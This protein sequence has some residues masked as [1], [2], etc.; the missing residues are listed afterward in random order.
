MIIGDLAR[1]N[2]QGRTA[3][4]YEN[5]Q[6]SDFG[7]LTAPMFT[8]V[9]PIMVLSPLVADGFDVIDIAIRLAELKYT[10]RYRAIA[11]DLPNGNMI[12]KEVRAH[13]PD[14]DFDLLMMSPIANDG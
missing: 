12:R 2:A 5:F 10:G 4:S 3:V 6:F 8:E 9:S 1:W 11:E 13:A 14:L 7:A